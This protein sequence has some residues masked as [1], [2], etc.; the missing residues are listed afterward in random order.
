MRGMAHRAPVTHG[1]PWVTDW[2]GE[3]VTQ[4]LT[5][6]WT[7]CLFPRS[8]RWL[9]CPCASPYNVLSPGFACRPYV[10]DDDEAGLEHLWSGA[11][12]TGSS[13]VNVFEHFSCAHLVVEHTYSSWCFLCLVFRYSFCFTCGSLC[14]PTTQ[15][16]MVLTW[17]LLTLLSIYIYCAS[18]FS[19]QDTIRW[20]VTFPW[21]YF[22][23][24]PILYSLQISVNPLIQTNMIKY[25]T[26]NW[27]LTHLLATEGGSG[28]DFVIQ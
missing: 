13:H 10:N 2:R 1:S 12:V 4:A 21:L 20:T 8:Q 23:I 19:F 7:L 25:F 16:W 22:Y 27:N 18:L 9:L 5:W 14:R 28:D 26:K 24:C 17:S 6:K 3:S 11:A 15:S